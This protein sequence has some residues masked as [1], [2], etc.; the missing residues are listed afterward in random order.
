M[1]A[2]SEYIMDRKGTMHTHIHM[3]MQLRIANPPTGL[4][5]RGRRKQENP[6]EIHMVMG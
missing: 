4:F 6:E 5:F 1:D 2:R 3:Q